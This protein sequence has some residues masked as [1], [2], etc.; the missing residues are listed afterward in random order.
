MDTVYRIV[1]DT[2]L[3]DPPAE[4]RGFSARDTVA[5]DRS[6]STRRSRGSIGRRSTGRDDR[7]GYRANAG[8]TR[9][10]RVVGVV[11]DVRNDSLTEAVQPE[12]YAT[13]GQTTN[14]VGGFG[15][16]HRRRSS[17]LARMR[18][19]VRS[20]SRNAA[21]DRGH[22]GRAAAATLAR[23][24]YAVLIGGLVLPSSSRPLA[25]SAGCRMASRS[26]GA[27]SACALGARR[28][29]IV[30]LVLAGARS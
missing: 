5:S 23:P 4:R 16:A 24:L 2:L 18:T 7:A 6:L 1:S 20:A 3:D 22:D 17:A 21:I 14:F 11:A 8:A 19:I 29:A 13:T 15:D 10:W 30:G 9:W 26:A 27:E 25:S 28:R 12:L